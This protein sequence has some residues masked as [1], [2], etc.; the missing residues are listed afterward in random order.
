M[1]QILTAAELA[2]EL[3]CSKSQIYRLIN[4]E[5]DGVSPLPYIPLGRKK[6]VRRSSLAVWM[7]ENEQNRATLADDSE[8][9]VVDA[10]ASKGQ[11]HA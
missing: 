10:C 1:D 3:R 4:G 5:V 11:R 6:V 2:S 9:N 7:H 8:M